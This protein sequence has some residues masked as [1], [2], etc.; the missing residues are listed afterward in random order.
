MNI[1]A[2]DMEIVEGI[3]NIIDKDISTHY[4]I[5]YLAEKAGMSESKLNEVFKQVIKTTL[6]AY[7]KNKRLLLAV[8]LLED[9]SKPLKQICKLS[10]FKNYSNFS[11]AFKK[12]YG[13]APLIYRNTFLKKNND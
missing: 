1:S 6:Y 5:G 7:L 13:T 12:H 10:G 9:G 8:T 11:R 4:A 2:F 3:K